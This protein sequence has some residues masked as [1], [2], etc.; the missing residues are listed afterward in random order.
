MNSAAPADG[1]AAALERVEARR[2]RR[3]VMLILCAPS[4]AGKT[5]L[6]RRL[7]AD[8]PELSLSV[9]CTTRDAR[10]GEREGREYFFTD[11]PAFD[12]LVAEDAF[13]EWADVHDH[14]YG[15]PRAPVLA[16]LEAGR[17]VLFDIDW[18]G[19]RSVVS[20]AP[21]DAVGVFVLPPSMTDLSRRLVARAQDS[22]AV[23]ARRL[24]RAAG[25]IAHWVE[26]PYVLV[27]DDFDRAYAELSHIYRAERLRRTRR[28]WLGGFVAGLGG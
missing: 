4:G 18:Q 9:S 20:K 15:T 25:E 21:E 28:P 11:R 7:T 6:A 8:F 3:G 19:A 12:R 2:L 13:L 17:D 22:D 5:S 23:I 10:P 24:A 26:F 14:R 27:N 16:A 1:D